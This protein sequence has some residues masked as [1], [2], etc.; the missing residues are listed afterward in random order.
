MCKGR[1]N[2]GI[3][4]V[5]M[6]A[7]YMKRSL[8]ARVRIGCCFC[9]VFALISPL[10]VKCDPQWYLGGKAPKNIMLGFKVLGKRRREDRQSVKEK[11]SLNL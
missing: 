9:F 1:K 10:H 4:S 2:R 6:G 3:L 7:T 5:N 11:E 8:V